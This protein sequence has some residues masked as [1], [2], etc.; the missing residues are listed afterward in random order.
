LSQQPCHSAIE[1]VLNTL[2]G[3]VISLLAG[4]VIY[5]PHGYDIPLRYLAS[6]TLKFKI[7][8]IA[9]SYVWRRAWNWLDQHGGG[10]VI[11]KVID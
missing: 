11:A 10:D 8:S 4:L 1:A 2:F 9:R 5:P 6:I 3:L 7:L